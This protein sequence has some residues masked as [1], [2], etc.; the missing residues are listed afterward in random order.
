MHRSSSAIPNLAC[1]IIAGNVKVT[2]P[3]VRY[4]CQG[5]LNSNLTR[6]PELTYIYKKESRQIN[7]INITT[8]SKEMSKGYLMSI[9]LKA[10][11]SWELI[12]VLLNCCVYVMGH[13]K[14]E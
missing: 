14:L 3:T 6:T 12:E 8:K 1:F 11:F 2:G 4:L 9:L 5:K 10:G 7:Q 13:N